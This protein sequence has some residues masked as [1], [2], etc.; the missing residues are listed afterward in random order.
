MYLVKIFDN[1]IISRF[2]QH[3]DKIN[4]TFADIQ[5]TF[6][7]RMLTFKF[8]FIRIVQYII[9]LPSHKVI[10]IQKIE[11]SNIDLEKK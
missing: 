4:I 3:V 11:T 9:N 7:I 5:L 8:I 1:M 2:K 10:K 6:I